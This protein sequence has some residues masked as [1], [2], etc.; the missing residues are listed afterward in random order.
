[1]N[2]NDTEL[3]CRA[4]SCWRVTVSHHLVLSFLTNVT[5][6]TKNQDEFI[7][8]IL[9]HT[10]VETNDISGKDLHVTETD[11]QINVKIK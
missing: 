5:D 11:M 6:P 7:L 9:Q 3:R 4:D 8:M 10:D 2:Q 1:M